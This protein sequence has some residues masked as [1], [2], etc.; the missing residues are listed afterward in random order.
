MA[1]GRAIIDVAA[2]ILHRVLVM[3]PSTY[4]V[5][6]SEMNP[7][8]GVVRLIVESE[9]L[10]GH[11]IHLTCEVVDVGSTRTVRMVPCG[12]IQAE[13]NFQVG[14]RRCPARF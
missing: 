10:A 4:R 6:G 5:V 1:T 13:D 7:A 12:R 2:D 14:A 8:I 9:D 11:D 3:F